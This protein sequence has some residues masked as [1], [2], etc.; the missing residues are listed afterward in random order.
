ML[1]MQA[2]L[3]WVLSE[4]DPAAAPQPR[5]SVLPSAMLLLSP[6]WVNKQ[7]SGESL[8]TCRRLTLSR[9]G[10]ASSFSQRPLSLIQATHSFSGHPND[11]KGKALDFLFCFSQWLQKFHYALALWHEGFP[12]YWPLSLPYLIGSSVV[13]GWRPFTF[14]IKKFLSCPPYDRN[15]EDTSS[16]EASIYLA[17]LSC[18]FCTLPIIWTSYIWSMIHI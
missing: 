8:S 18:E 12:A 14:N 5:I 7:I 1:L 13:Q 15:W 9:S 11:Y 2:F 4:P 6:F 3:S 16:F 17:M 10:E